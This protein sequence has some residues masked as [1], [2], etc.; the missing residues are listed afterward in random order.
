MY[1][2]DK[3]F[4][5]SQEGYSGVYFPS[6]EA[7]R[8]MNTKI[9]FQ[10][11]QKQFVTRVHTLSYFLHNINNNKD[12]DLSTSSPCLTRSVFVLLMTSQSIPDD[13]TMTRK[14][15]CDHLNSDIQL[16]R[17][18]FY[19]WRYWRPVVWERHI[20]PHYNGPWL[21]YAFCVPYVSYSLCIW[22]FCHLFLILKYH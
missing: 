20:E 12:D 19:S 3:L 18:R 21:C 10:W 5:C 8:E 22:I 17:Y 11:A 15:W 1:S 13:V 4:Q 9:T 7:T 16:V 14:L 6:C 2:S